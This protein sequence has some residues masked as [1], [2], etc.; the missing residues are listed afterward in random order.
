[1]KR[2]LSN[3]AILALFGLLCLILGPNHHVQAQGKVNFD[4]DVSIRLAED[5]SLLDGSGFLAQLYFG[6]TNNPH[7]MQPTGGVVLVNSGKLTAPSPNPRV[8]T[9]NPNGS[10]IYVQIRIWNSLDNFSFDQVK[11][12]GGRLG[13]SDVIPV[14]LS[15]NPTQKLVF[16]NDIL[17][18]EITGNENQ[19]GLIHFANRTQHVNSR[20]FGMNG[21]PLSGDQYVAQLYVG[22]DP[23]FLN[24]V[25]GLR[26]FGSGDLAGYLVGDNEI[27][28]A[29][30]V[31][32][33]DPAY[34]KIFVWEKEAGKT[35]EEGVRTGFQ[36][37][38]SGTIQLITGG[39][40]FPTFDT[41]DLDGLQ[42]FELRTL[43]SP[44]SLGSVYFSNR[45]YD[46]D[47]K[48]NFYIPVLMP[49]KSQVQGSHFKAQLYFGRDPFELSPA[50]IEAPFLT[51]LVSSLWNPRVIHIPEILPGEE[52]YVR[53]KIWD[54]SQAESFE[55]A[56][57]NLSLRGQSNILK[58][59]TGG[60]G[61]PP[62][63]PTPLTG[64]EP[65]Q[66]YKGSIP[67][68]VSQPNALAI[69]EGESAQLEFQFEAS[70]PYQITWFKDNAPIES[71][72]SSVLSVESASLDNNGIYHAVLSNEAGSIMTE[73]VAINVSKKII[74]PSIVS[75]N[76][77]ELLKVGD[78]LDLSVSYSGSEP[79]RI[80]WF[81]DGSIMVPNGPSHLQLSGINEDF[82]GT[83]SVKVSNSAGEAEK[84]LGDLVVYSPLSWVQL[85]TSIALTSNESKTIS[86]NL[87]GTGPITYKWILNG[88]LVQGSASSIWKIQKASEVHAG[89]LQITAT[90]PY[91]EI[92]SGIIELT[93]HNA[94]EI[95]S[96]PRNFY[97]T[98]DENSELE[99][100]TSGS[101][102][103]H[104]SWTKNGA[105]IPS[106]NA[107]KISFTNPTESDAGTYI[108]TV[109]NNA[110]ETTSL[111]IEVE[112][113]ARPEILSMS[114]PVSIPSSHSALFWASV[115][116]TQDTTYKWYW[117]NNIIYS[118]EDPWLILDDLPDDALGSI[119]FEA[120]NGFG[121]VKSE[122]FDL[123]YFTLPNLSFQPDH[124]VER[125]LPHE[126]LTT[127]GGQFIHLVVSSPDNAPIVVQEIIP[128]GVD[129]IEVGDGGAF[130][131]ESR[132]L[133]WDL[134]TSANLVLSYKV[135]SSEQNGRTLEWSGSLNNGTQLIAS[136]GQS[137]LMDYPSIPSDLSPKDGIISFD[138]MSQ[139]V[140]H[141]LDGDLWNNE[142]ISLDYAVR[143]LSLFQSGGEYKFDD[144]QIEPFSWIPSNP[145]KVI[146]EK[147]TIVEDIK[148]HFV[149]LGGDEDAFMQM[150]V[151]IPEKTA[152]A[153]G[154]ELSLSKGWTFDQELNPLSTA[155]WIF[156]DAQSR[157]LIVNIFPTGED[158]SPTMN[159]DGWISFDGS[160]TSLETTAH[161]GEAF[162]NAITSAALNENEITLK[163]T[164]DISGTWLIEESID[165]R[166][167]Y[168]WKS[169]QLQPGKFEI[170]GTTS[171]SSQAFYRIRFTND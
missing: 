58:I 42:S 60:Y 101:P 43:E 22:P 141:Y 80:D 117:E 84:I 36:F 99:I 34:A 157:K 18:E 3:Y 49:D 54:S 59:K 15:D 61:S 19:P 65:I 12:Y 45:F 154:L 51:G 165:F 56:E 1:M 86:I 11:N 100:I 112:F 124:A 26:S 95:L 151:E 123:R 63:F 10:T 156:Q 72:S 170:N 50:G 171:P 161:I 9:N 120:S 162:T 155:K 164:V 25:D 142:R 17:I 92:Q 5:Q 6:A 122:E 143:T 127:E 78:T 98:K 28:E 121:S 93:I 104:Y 75:A 166:R 135:H 64:L 130:D 139:Y 66:L 126:G 145:G 27:I 39:G 125:I 140:S 110:G 30:L 88:Q 20:I 158:I 137:K 79:S 2:G 33:G 149:G 136:S 69:L 23:N 21:Q 14:T 152:L 71:G 87:S 108:L 44:P 67:R 46:Q 146:D 134:P 68:I 163:G 148:I 83:Y 167:W 116:D 144:S 113:G 106:I 52:I 105:S 74:P 103:L 70:E 160:I 7:D 13:Y 8:L 85:P 115:E 37:G 169:V 47:L 129:I 40:F 89:N 109:S 32:P 82:S 41:P 73:R 133:V 53:V 138:E 107:N 91:D 114:S 168:P 31:N 38:S 76:V 4:T 24:P 119:W 55:S 96:Q 132:T 77:N 94:P 111:P 128:E 48:N 150:I 16:Q 147:S 159:V 90:S 97:I 57:N 118:S 35:Y 62:K 81:K 102:P 29:S 153:S 131:T